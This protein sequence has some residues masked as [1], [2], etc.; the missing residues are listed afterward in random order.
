METW[1]EKETRIIAGHLVT[2]LMRV[3]TQ[4][5]VFRMVCNELYITRMHSVIAMLAD[6]LLIVVS[7]PWY[8]I[9]PAQNGI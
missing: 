7:Y 2:K 8:S 9:L 3:P 5:E 6:E 4:L 1:T